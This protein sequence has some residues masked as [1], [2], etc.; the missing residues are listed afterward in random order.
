MIRQNTFLIL[1]GG[2]LDKTERLEQQIAGARVIAADGGMRHAQMLSVEPEL[3]VGDFDSSP[4]Q[5]MEAWPDTRRKPYPAAKNLTDGEIAVE[6]ALAL[7]AERIIL[8]GALGGERSDH[9]FMHMTFAC[10]L[11]QRGIDVLLTSGTEEAWPLL[12]GSRTFD[13]PPSSLFSILNFADVSGLHITGAR[14][15]LQ[16][17]ELEFGS[18]RTLSNVAEG[19]VTISL[20]SGSALLL[21]RP[22]DQSG[23]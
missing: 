6:E 17:F 10:A 13:L 12:T 9:A 4:E 18:S 19:P 2:N 3:W 21:S 1:L 11:S 22:F 5:L 8:A 16:A 14:Y 7:G 23:R 20:K 15:E